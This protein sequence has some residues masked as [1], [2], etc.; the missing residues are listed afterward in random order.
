MGEVYNSVIGF[1]PQSGSSRSRLGWKGMVSIMRA[2]A[3]RDYAQRL[4]RGQQPG[5]G[6]CGGTGATLSRGGA[7]AQVVARALPVQGVAG[8]RNHLPHHPNLTVTLENVLFL[9][10]FFFFLRGSLCARRR[11]RVTGSCGCIRVIEALHFLGCMALIVGFS[12]CFSG[13]APSP[14]P[15]PR[16]FSAG[17]SAA[18]EVAPSF[19]LLVTGGQISP[20]ANWGQ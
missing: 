18:V 14:P 13:F 15:P 1:L 20:K 4:C 6:C 12:I 11:N 3:G 8:E 16:S 5:A 2:R 7:E 19:I 17:S 10:F 9:F